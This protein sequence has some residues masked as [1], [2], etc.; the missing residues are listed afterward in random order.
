M[1]GLRR[2]RGVRPVPTSESERHTTA[3]D[4]GREIAIPGPDLHP[5]RDTKAAHHRGLPREATNGR[6]PPAR[7]LPVGHPH[8]VRINAPR[9]VR[10]PGVPRAE[11]RV[12]ARPGRKVPE[13]EILRKEADKIIDE[14]VFGG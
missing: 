5:I 11:A 3:G 10:H 8:P 1:I 13:A 2:N 6:V 7:G 4:P 12:P 9:E 14:S